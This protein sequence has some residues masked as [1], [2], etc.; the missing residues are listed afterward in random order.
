MRKQKIV[1]TKNEKIKTIHD[2]DI[3][4]FKI[5]P[6]DGKRVEHETYSML[7]FRQ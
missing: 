3:V 6:F 7:P 5:L 1:N 4:D 2:I